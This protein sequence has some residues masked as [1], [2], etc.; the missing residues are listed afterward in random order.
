MHRVDRSTPSDRSRCPWPWKTARA[1][2]SVRERAVSGAMLANLMF[3]ASPASISTNHRGTVAHGLSEVVATVGL[4][5]V[6]FSL[7]R[8]GRGRPDA[9]RLH[10][11]GVLVHPLLTV[12]LVTLLTRNCTR[13]KTGL[14]ILNELGR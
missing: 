10:R 13:R 14:K 6:I 12:A 11:D 7:A 1:P 3:S 9:G 2:P 4:I 5:L 8:S